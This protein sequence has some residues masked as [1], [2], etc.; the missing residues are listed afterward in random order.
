MAGAA[1]KLSRTTK[2]NGLR[3]NELSVD[4]TPKSAQLA[5]ITITTRARHYFY[6]LGPHYKLWP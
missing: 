5:S 1:R 6:R 2:A 4:L 3:T